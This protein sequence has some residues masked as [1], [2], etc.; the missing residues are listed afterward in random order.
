MKK[1]LFSILLIAVF[2]LPA[3][4]K[5]KM[6]HG[7]GQGN[8]N[9][10]KM[11]DKGAMGGDMMCM[12]HVRQVGLT[13]DQMAKMKK[14]R[15]EMQKKQIRFDADEKL[16]QIEL[17]EIK[18]VKDFDLAKASDALKKIGDMKTAHHLEMLKVKKDMRSILTDEQFKEM[19]KMC[20]MK[21]DKKK[22]EKKKTH[23]PASKKQTPQQ[24]ADEPKSK[25]KTDDAGHKH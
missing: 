23:K 12:E 25:S 8:G 22:H 5:T 11:C 21:M 2:T 19:D 18:E 14:L 15:R 16:A 6:G 20:M 17:Q 24:P 3:F 13:D 10:M 1:I 7:D 4:A 9:M